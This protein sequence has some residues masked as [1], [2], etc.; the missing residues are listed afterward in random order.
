MNTTT[1]QM[2]K[3]SN[4]MSK[5]SNTTHTVL[6]DTQIEL[7]YKIQDYL[8]KKEYVESVEWIRPNSQTF[9]KVVHPLKKILRILHNEYYDEKD[10]KDLNALRE[11]Y[12]LATTN[13][14]KSPYYK[15]QY[16]DDSNDWLNT[17][18]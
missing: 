3:M 2:S 16:S 13:V 14:D 12:M 4:Q 6:S 15:K 11:M 10:K 17:D 18:N 5:M 9:C 1:T 7:L 8:I